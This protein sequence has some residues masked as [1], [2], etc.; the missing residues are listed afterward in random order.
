MKQLFVLIHV[1]LLTLLAYEGVTIMYRGLASPLQG[2]SGLS[3]N[4]GPVAVKVVEKDKITTEKRYQKISARNLFNVLK[5]KLKLAPAEK[6]KLEPEKVLKKTKLRL[7]LWGTVTGETPSSSFAVIE[8][9]IKSKQSLLKEGDLIQGA[10]V[11]HIMRSKVILSLNGVDQILEVSGNL[12]PSKGN[13]SFMG[14]GNMSKNIFRETGIDDRP[15]ND[16]VSIKKQLK[17]RPY[18]KNGTPSGVLLYGIRPGS[19]FLKLGLK[20]G[21]I[22]LKLNE[23][24]TLT[25]DDGEKLY[26]E[27]ESIS[28]MRFVVRRR[29]KEKEI[30]YD[31]EKNSYMVQAV[32]DE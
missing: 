25:L 19:K 20:N 6:A 32:T 15:A 7:V 24:P 31:A 13:S 22:L 29:G 11:K 3:D 14:Q 18:L 16:M 23:T 21:D 5:N 10:I 2:E 26:Q 12:P 9:K 4:P 30:L 17:I 8:D 28:N 27:L 1:L